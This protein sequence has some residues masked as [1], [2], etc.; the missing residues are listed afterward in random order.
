[1]SAPTTTETYT[2][3]ISSKNKLFDTDTEDHF[4]VNLPNVIPERFKEFYVRCLSLQ[5]ETASASNGPLWRTLVAKVRLGQNVIASDPVLT[6]VVGVM[7][8]FADKS[9]LMPEQ[10]LLRCSRTSRLLKSGRVQPSGFQ[11]SGGAASRAECRRWCCW[12]MGSS[13]VF[14][15]QLYRKDDSRVGVHSDHGANDYA[16]L[17]RLQKVLTTF[18]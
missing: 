11:Q 13:R 3:M 9:H 8:N 12:R 7:F 15:Q 10:P 16:E 4:H 2:V 6:D 17:S 18:A 1:M 14:E 5:A